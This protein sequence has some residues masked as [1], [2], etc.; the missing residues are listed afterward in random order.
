M[1]GYEEHH[2]GERPARMSR[3]VITPLLVAAGMIGLPLL[4]GVSQCSRLRTAE[5][6]E[7]EAVDENTTYAN[8]SFLPGAGYYHASYQAWFPFPYNFHDPGRGYFRGGQWFQTQEEEKRTIGVASHPGAMSG[9]VSS[10]RPTHEAVL[11]A[12][13]AAATSHATTVTRGGF[14]GSAHSS[15]S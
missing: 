7:A 2:F 3:Q 15:S 14:G 11:H 6:T 12:N 1:S 8:N 5:M 4:I 10:S 13:A 9:F